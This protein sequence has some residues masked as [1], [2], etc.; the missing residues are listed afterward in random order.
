MR[1][2]TLFCFTLVFLYLAT[3]SVATGYE[4]TFTPGMSVSTEYTDNLYLSQK[5]GEHDIVTVFSPTFL[6][7]VTERRNGMALSYSPGYSLYE[8]W[9]DNNAWRHNLNFFGWVDITEHTRLEIDDAFL[10]TE[11]PL[12]EEDVYS[13]DGEP[14]VELDG[15]TERNRE[16]YYTN[17]GRIN[18]AHQF[19]EEDSFF[20]QYVH[21]L[22]RSDDPEDEDHNG[23]N[24]SI[25]M[26]YW[27]T[28]RWGVE[29]E[30][31]YTTTHYSGGD[32]LD[33]SDDFEEWDGS[34]RLIRRFT[35]QL[36]GF[37]RYEYSTTDYDDLEEDYSVHNGT[38]GF[39]YDPSENRH[40]SFD[41]GYWKQDYDDSGGNSGMTVNGVFEQLFRRGLISLGCSAG[42]DEAHYGAENLG[43]S[44]Y[45]E[46][47]G[48][49]EYLLSR[50]VTADFSGSYRNDDYQDEAPSRED[51][52]KR[53]R[54]GLSWLCRDWVSLS[55]AYSYNVVDSNDDDESYRENSVLFTVSLTP[56]HP[57]RLT[58]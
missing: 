34:L 36:E 24:P 18:L 29:T 17:I 2:N 53:L 42:E 35:H 4:V 8:E 43:L 31:G 39:I 51:K 26:T 1:K 28:P 33:E 49:V 47:E 50:R 22:R 7:E 41:I 23:H 10:R 19:G 56:S 20:L 3:A 37:V 16:P 5:N 12:D 58:D 52:T 55:V 32:A 6:L 40:I 44:K 25:G 54:V 30:A 9:S 13:P 21:R 48:R 15:T 45:Y 27:F 38:T 57:Y 14:L 11:D 46:A